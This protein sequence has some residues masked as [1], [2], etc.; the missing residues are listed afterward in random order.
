MTQTNVMVDANNRA[1]LIDFGNS[2]VI[3]TPERQR[4]WG[5]M[6]TL[7]WQ[8]AEIHN[9]VMHEAPSPIVHTISSEIWS[10]GVVMFEVRCSS[11]RQAY[12]KR[13]PHVNSR[14]LRATFRTGV[15]TDTTGRRR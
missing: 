14:Y 12:T 8:A 1:V 4:Q 9:Q 15:L 7:A 5:K 13:I 6:S 11:L 3:Q 10:F 2:V